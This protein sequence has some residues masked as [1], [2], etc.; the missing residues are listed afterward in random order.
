[1]T[2]DT[3]LTIDSQRGQMNDNQER[4]KPNMEPDTTDQRNQIILLRKAALIAGLAVLIMA[5]TVP[6][7]EFYIFPKL[8][9]Y[10]NAAQTTTN[11]SNNSTLFSIAIFI[12]FTT[13]ICDI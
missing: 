12:H 11:I 5:L 13:V 9:D 6:F 10:K 1:M 2:N 7:V 3:L 8:I 4:L